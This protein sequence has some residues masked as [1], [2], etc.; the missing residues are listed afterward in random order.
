MP[1]R[2]IPGAAKP[3]C[4]WKSLT[5][6]SNRSIVVALEIELFEGHSTK[7]SCEQSQHGRVRDAEEMSA[8]LH[9][10]LNTPPCLSSQKKKSKEKAPSL[11][12]KFQGGDL[13]RNKQRIVMK[14]S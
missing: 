9:L 3:I 14:G 8:G 4:F 2:M 1:L 5:H 11:L 12:A 10:T 6:H 13:Q 7:K